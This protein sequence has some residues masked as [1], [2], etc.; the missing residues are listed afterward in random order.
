MRAKLSIR[1]TLGDITP[2]NL[3]AASAMASRVHQVTSGG[4]PPA[5]NA[6]EPVTKTVGA[7]QYVIIAANAA[8][9]ASSSTAKCAGIATTTSTET[10]TAAGTVSVTPIDAP[11]QIWLISPNVAATYGQGTTQNQTTYNALV[12]ARVLL[13]STSGAWTILASDSV[14]NGCVV[15]NLDITKYPGKVAFS[16]RA[17]T[18]YLA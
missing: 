14:N 6:G 3:S 17:G 10:A 9:D 16:F 7:S 15:E 11:N 2:F 1:A 18:S 5:I 8:Y 12:G 4:T 13:Q